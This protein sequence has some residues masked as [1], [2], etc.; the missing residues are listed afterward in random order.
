MNYLVEKGPF[1]LKREG[2]RRIT[3]RPGNHFQRDVSMRRGK[4]FNERGIFTPRVLL[5][6][7]LVMA[8]VLLALFSVTASPQRAFKRTS[9]AAASPTPGPS[10]TVMPSPNLTDQ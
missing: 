1:G 9:A 10:W 3:K 2:D 6:F 4:A 7:S 5:G 8:G